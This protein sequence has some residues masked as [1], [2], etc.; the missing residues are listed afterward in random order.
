M[1]KIIKSG[2][3]WSEEE[4]SFLK[5]N[6]N[7]LSINNLIKELGRSKNSIVLKVRKLGLEFKNKN[8]WTDEEINFLKDNINTLYLEEIANYLNRTKVS[9]NAKSQ[10]LGLV[11]KIDGHR[12]TDEEVKFLK[13][14]YL[15]IAP[16]NIAINLNLKEQQVKGKLNCLKLKSPF[17]REVNPWTE[18]QIKFVENNFDKYSYREIGEIIGR[19]EKSISEKFKGLKGGKVVTY[20]YLSDFKKM[21]PE[22]SYVL[23][24]ITGDGW[25]SRPD[26]DYYQLM[27]TN[28]IDDSIYLE[29]TFNKVTQW[30]VTRKKENNTKRKDQ[31][32]F[33]ISNKE[34]I[35]FLNE[36]L[37]LKNKNKYFSQKLID[38]IPDDLHQY[39]LRGLFDA[40]GGAYLNEKYFSCDIAS[41]INFDWASLSN[42]IESKTGLIGSVY[43]YHIKKSNSYASRFKFTGGKAAKFLSYIYKDFPKDN[44]GF[45]RKFINYV[46]YLE[47]R[48]ISPY[49]HDRMVKNEVLIGV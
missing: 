22:L 14:N 25:I 13:D 40:D 45:T 20:D 23:G 1:S 38:F 49:Y 39:L 34:L 10:K 11:M 27:V 4:I 28:K 48:A 26:A 15:S 9:V 43:Q 42:F 35:S 5:R 47:R 6:I 16:K 8:R 2:L 12:W 7:I 36:E 19:P 18:E 29:K 32:R 17:L 33:T 30:G 3:K 44:I 46:K 21:T 37:D 31:I 24:F 41:N